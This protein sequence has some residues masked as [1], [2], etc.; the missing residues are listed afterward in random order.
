VNKAYRHV[1]THAHEDEE[2]GS[3]EW[4]SQITAAKECLLDTNS[5]RLYN[6]ALERF[7]ITDGH[8]L[9]PNFEKSIT[10]KINPARSY[11]EE[12][13]KDMYGQP[14]NPQPHQDGDNNVP[15]YKGFRATLSPRH[16]FG[17]L[18]L[19]FLLFV[20][21]VAVAYAVFHDRVNREVVTLR[22]FDDGVH[23]HTLTYEVRNTVVHFTLKYQ[24]H[25][26][27]EKWVNLENLGSDTRDYLRFEFGITN[28][29]ALENEEPV[30]EKSEAEIFGD[31]EWAEY[32]I[33]IY[34]FSYKG[35]YIKEKHLY[36]GSEFRPERLS[37]LVMRKF[38]CEDRD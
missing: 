38:Y 5:R 28:V 3:I 35:G 1:I 2:G 26:A 15:A 36:N 8:Q 21:V 19:C 7:E 6:D 25:Y 24:P 34:H 14:V 13:K 17:G 31:G 4:S 29:S 20:G 37:N 16:L 18:G 32:F 30:T 33:A 27:D 12:P 22:L 23:Y 11:K 9:D 10:N